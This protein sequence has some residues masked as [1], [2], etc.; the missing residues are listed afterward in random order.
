MAIRGHCGYV[1][2]A[3]ARTYEG[4]I[5][6]LLVGVAVILVPKHWT[7]SRVVAEVVACLGVLGELVWMSMAAAPRF[8]RSSVVKRALPLPVDLELEPPEFPGADR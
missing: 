3:N 8:P 2:Y 1:A 7:M 5:L 6:A 4:G